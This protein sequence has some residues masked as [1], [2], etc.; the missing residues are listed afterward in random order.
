MITTAVAVMALTS[1]IQAASISF[2]NVKFGNDKKDNERCVR[3][4]ITNY[5]HEQDEEDIKNKCKPTVRIICLEKIDLTHLKDMLP[6]DCDL[7][8]HIK[9]WNCDN[10]TP[11]PP[12][13]SVPDSGTAMG[14]M[15]MAMMAVE[16]V[17]RFV[18]K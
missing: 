9:D 16:G 10:N 18:R 4:M 8:H 11:Q 15:G 3:N 12:P 1:Q 13:T 17:R 2:K 5:Q 6:K 14:L 7:S